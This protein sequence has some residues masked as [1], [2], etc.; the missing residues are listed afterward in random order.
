MQAS[1]WHPGTHL[2][3]GGNELFTDGS[4]KWFKFSQMYFLT[5]WKTALPILREAFFYQDPGDFD[6]ALIAQL[7]QLASSVFK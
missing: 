3:E 5:T 1:S 7:P 6:P 4:A 2:P